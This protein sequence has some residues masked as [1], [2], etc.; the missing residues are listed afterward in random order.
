MS[1]AAQLLKKIELLTKQVANIDHEVKK[2]KSDIRKL[3]S[4]KSHEDLESLDKTESLEK[5]TRDVDLEQNNVR[6][7]KT[8]AALSNFDVME[9]KIADERQSYAEGLTIHGLSRIATGRPFSK[10]IWTLLVM[11]SLL[12]ALL[13]SKEHFEAYLGDHSVTHTAITAENEIAVPS[14][15]ICNYDGINRERRHFSGTPPFY[16]R[17]QLVSIDMRECGNNLTKCGYAGRTM[18]EVLFYSSDYVKS[19]KLNHLVKFDDTTNCFTVSGF[20]Q[21]FPSDIFSVQLVANRTGD[22]WSELYVNPDYETFHEAS[23]TIYWASEGFYHVNVVKKKVTRLG[24][25][26]TECIKGSGTYTQNKF[27]GVYTVTKCKKGCFWEAV[28][29]KCGAIPP[30]Y[31]KH[32]REPYRFNNK[33]FVDDV[34]GDA[35]LREVELDDKVTSKCNTQCTIQPCYEEDIKIS[36][37]FHR[38]PDLNFLEFAFTY[39]SFMV[40]TIEEVP[41]YTWQDLFANFGGC[42]GLMTGASIL[43]ICEL[44]IFF[45]LVCF[46]FFDIYSKIGSKITPKSK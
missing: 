39:Q 38:S 33:T 29:E 31:K 43:S 35:C 45:G 17:P 44:F 30:M 32:M 8:S 11:A 9:E 25:P 1:D 5:K 18:V 10:V 14:I 21:T 23:P 22:L 36:L 41:A 4:G 13:I 6:K 24:L 27:T 46:D 42:V 12:T 19:K 37:D 3:S 20:T 7:P 26:Y 16:T 2:S 34:T 15:T 40:E 28:F